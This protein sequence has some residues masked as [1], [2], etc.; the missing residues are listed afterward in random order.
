MLEALR[1]GA[2]TW[3]AKLLFGIL[4]MSFALWGI[5]GVFRGYG[6]GSIAKIGSTEIPA[7]DFQRAFQNEIEKFSRDANKRITAEQA[8]AIG[9]DRRVL[10]QLIGGAAVEAHAKNLGL[11]LSDKT[12]V[13]DIANDPDFKGP[14]GK[15]SKQGFDALLRQN[16]LSEQGFLK[17]RRKDELRKQL[18]G[19]FVTGQAT[20]KPLVEIMHA[21]NGEKRALQSLTI[22]ADKAVTVAEPEDSKLKEIYEAGKAKFMTPEYR[23]FS[24][25]LL[26]IDGLK[27]QVV[28]KDEEIASAYEATKDSYD[29]AEQRRIQQIA[30][31]DKAAAEVAKKALSDGS[32]SFGDAAKETG[33]KDTDVDLG[34][35]T[36]RGLIDPKIAGV[37]FSLAKDAISDVVEGR[38]A[39]VLVR[40]T[41]IE[42][43]VTRT[44][45][46]VKDQVRD[47]LA[48]EKAKAELQ[49][50]RDEVDDL[51]NAGKTLQ[52]IAETL[53]LSF[54]EVAS[55]DQRG[56]TPDGKP[57][58]ESPD[59]Q[60]LVTQAF[61][62]DQA[63]EQDAVEL[64]DGGYGW[65][66]HLSTEVP[67][68]KPFEEV[69]DQVKAQHLASERKR[70]VE[71]LAGK[72]VERVNAGEPMSALE[73]ASGGTKVEKIE[74][75]SRSSIPTGLSESAVIQAFA[76][77]KG[78]ATSAESADHKSRTIVVVDDIIPA[79]AATK[80]Q[81]DKL[82]HDVEAD[83]TNQALNEYTTAL[84]N[85]LGLHMNEDE[86]KRA[87]G[88]PEPQ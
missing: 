25:L 65:V 63:T 35:I 77:Q 84:Q 61:A 13:D 38:F 15:F 54:V 42:P 5:S 85:R 12:L 86:M 82:S 1:R 67:K 39:T 70:L 74:A 75:F 49:K 14:D 52:E 11:D 87:L 56:L 48:G 7:E 60:K 23:K 57:A 69:K 37:A 46:D 17:I 88:V 76:L 26:T 73:A 28:V 30:F 33:A 22:D 51:R 32:K 40:V 36:K 20:P 21:Y 43:G 10:K 45:A 16:G 9:L 78:K 4:V 66:N 53:K 44:L 18:I 34:M 6:R 59:A 71:E 29:T 47:K 80:E 62:P 81:T 68:Q 27:K 31:K 3:V 72:L 19:A 8:R 50:K 2:Q 58:L 79:A 41:Q 55:A 83:L 64:G 24:A